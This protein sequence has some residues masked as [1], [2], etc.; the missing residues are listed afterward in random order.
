MV[1]AAR[2]FLFDI[3]VAEFQAIIGGMRNWRGKTEDIVKCYGGQIMNLLS[4]IAARFDVGKIELIKGEDQINKPTVM[5]YFERL[6]A[7]AGALGFDAVYILVDRV[8]ETSITQNDANASFEFIQSLVLDLHVLET[9]SVAFKFFLWDQ[10]RNRYL[11]AGARTDRIPLHVLNWNL[12][13]MSTMLAER[14][15]AYS[16][17]RVSSLNDL[18]DG[19]LAYDIHSLVCILAAGSPR[20]MIRMCK[21]IV[22]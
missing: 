3:N 12:K 6:V 4:A 10:I 8:D 22:R 21:A 16:D 18:L 20:D 17:G 11:D 13:E 15:K 9:K 14:L 1:K 5:A 2:T 7:L 19:T